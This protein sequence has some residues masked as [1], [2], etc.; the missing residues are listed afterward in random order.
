M[1][2][3][4]RDVTVLILKKC[5]FTNTCADIILDYRGRCQR[6]CPNGFTVNL[7][8]SV[9]P[10]TMSIFIYKEW[11]VFSVLLS[12]R[13]ASSLFFL[14]FL[15]NIN[16]DFISNSDVFLTDWFIMPPTYIKISLG[17]KPL[18]YF[19]TNQIFNYINNLETKC[20]DSSPKQG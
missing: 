12:T 2:E 19:V 9:I 5:E 11:I 16:H 13:A 1:G 3:A 20:I 10:K 15:V 7:K 4:T 18:H 8:R 14:Y 6:A 17:Q